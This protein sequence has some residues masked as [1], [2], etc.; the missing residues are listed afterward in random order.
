MNHWPF[1]LAS[2]GLTFLAVAALV[3]W[4][5]SAMRRAERAADELGRGR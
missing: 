5:W 3:L 2:Y 4:S 1:I